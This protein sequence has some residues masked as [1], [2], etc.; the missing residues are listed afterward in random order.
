MSYS[1]L[2]FR[3]NMEKFLSEIVSP[4]G[5]YDWLNKNTTLNGVPF[6]CNKYPFQKQ[7]LEDMSLNLSCI[8][9][10]QIGLTE[11]QIRKA[12]AIVARHPN[13]NLIYTLPDKD[14]RKRV[15][16]T[17][18]QP[19]LSGTP[20]FNETDKPVRSI[21][22]TQINNSFMLLFPADEKAATSQPA[23]I[24]FNDEVDLSD[25]AILALFN[26][27]MQGS[28]WKMNQ[29]FSTPTYTGF[30]ITL[31]YDL[32]DQHN[33]VYKCPHCNHYQ[34]PEF[35]SRFIKVPR[36]PEDF[37]DL[38]KLE[39]SWINKLQVAVSEAYAV[40][41]KCGARAHYGHEENHQWVAKHPHHRTRGYKVTPFATRNL[42]PAYVLSQLFE[43]KRADNLKGFFNTVL[44][45]AY[46]QGDERLSENLLRILFR[47]NPDQ[48][49]PEEGQ[50]Y[51]IGIDMGN[52]C[53]VTIKR[54]NAFD[55][56]E[57]VFFDIIRREDLYERI[58]GLDKMYHFAKG[59]ID[60]LPLMDL[61]DSIRELT[62]GRIMPV[63]YG[64]TGGALLTE[65][66]NEYDRLAYYMLARTE[67]LDKLV[68]ALKAGYVMFAGYSG[69]QETIISHL[70]DMVRKIV[71][72]DPEKLPIWEK[73]TGND[74]F[75]HALGY[76]YQAA[77]QYYKGASSSEHVGSVIYFAG[78][79]SGSM[80]TTPNRLL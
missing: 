33:Y 39:E 50:K 12:L 36:L 79:N 24:V 62:G 58:K 18:I 67:H 6:N 71:K 45:E 25:Q 29:R 70:R 80:T 64:G 3:P 63:Q 60:R 73:L 37:E 5:Y 1:A 75:F 59:Y 77:Y 15:Y 23:D 10:S 26:S 66:Y 55:N 27:R 31:S 51:F 47:P 61:A 9:P 20:I 54:G 19:F 72:N 65:K 11:V 74:H 68:H 41:E 32:S 38:T 49:M 21:E 46:E 14:M 52:M 76:G 53:H 16:Q 42:T 7:I 22:V 34:F 43:Y 13:R 17:R 30:G 78:L 56:L 4:S 69:F 35:N 48:V 28:D 2:S 44:G 8:K 40:C 57:T